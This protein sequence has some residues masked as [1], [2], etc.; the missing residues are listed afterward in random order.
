MGFIYRCLIIDDESP[1]HRALASHIS[2][3]DFLEHTASAFSGKQALQMLNEFQYD[4]IF[5]DINMPVISGI[6]IMELQPNRPLTIVTT[7]YSDYALTAYK[8]QAIDYLL[9]PI[10]LE[11]FTKA[12]EKLKAYYTG[13]ELVRKKKSKSKR[14]TFKFNGELKEVSL[15]K[16]ICIESIGHYLKLYLE[17]NKIPVVIYG[18]LQNVLSELDDADFIRVHRSYIVNTKKIRC[19][20]QNVLFLLNDK[21]VPVGRKYKILLMGSN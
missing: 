20:K 19:Q 15:D 11:D 10:S 18:T 9:K 3:F 4:V 13:Y 8:Q 2:K 7:A 5:L 16:V 21:E 6:D 12:I 17:D 14:L 1:A